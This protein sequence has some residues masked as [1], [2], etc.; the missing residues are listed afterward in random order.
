MLAPIKN[1]VREGFGAFVDDEALTRG[2]AIAFYAVTALA[3]VLYITAL[4]CGLIFGRA[5]TTGALARELTHV[6]GPDGAR[7]VHGA[8]HNAFDLSRGIWP[9]ILGAVVLVVAAS[10]LFGEMQAALNAI[11]KA[12]PRGSFLRRLARDRATSLALV[13]AMGFVLVGSTLCTAAITALGSRVE[14]VLPVGEAAARV[15]S[16]LLSLGLTAVLF[17]AIYKILPDVD[18]EWRDVA[19]GATG[20]AILFALG[21]LGIGFYLAMGSVGASYGKAGSLIVLLFWVYYSS[22]VFLLGAEFTKVWATRH[23]SQRPPET[24]ANVVP[25]PRK[26]ERRA[27]P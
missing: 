26:A 16:Y 18:L 23:G 15:I 1:M 3:P 7:L 25:L 14:Y 4:I 24:S 22:E 27:M 21:Q 12:K 6:A 20:T 9:N 13:L 19:V 8:I 5:A 17:A 10:G 11:W 2:A